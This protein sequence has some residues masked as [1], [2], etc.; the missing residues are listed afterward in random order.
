MKNRF[1]LRIEIQVAKNE[2]A[3]FIWEKFFLQFKAFCFKDSV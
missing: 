2:N 3:K 1:E